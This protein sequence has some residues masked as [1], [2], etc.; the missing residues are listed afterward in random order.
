MGKPMNKIDFVVTWVDGNDPEWIIERERYVS[1]KE[2]SGNTKNRFRDWDLMRYWFRGVEKFAPWVNKIYFIT[3]GQIPRWLNIEHPKLRLIKHVDYIPAKNLPTFNSNVIELYL[4]NIPELCEQFV[5]FNDDMFLTNYSD[6]QDF[7][8][9][10]MPCD[11]V[12]LGQVQSLDYLNVFPHTILNNMAIINKY[13]NKKEVLRKN[14]K[15]YFS[16][17]YGKDLIRNILLSP[18]KYFSAFFD[19]HLPTSHLKSTFEEVWEVE[20]ELLSECGTH[21]FRSSKD[22][23]HWLMKNWRFCKGQFMPRSNTWGKCFELGQDENVFAAIKTQKYKMVCLNDSNPD[24]DF[25]VY[26]KK[27]SA[28]FES[29]LPEKSEY[30]K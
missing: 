17:L 26:Q 23:T 11:T 28:V 2:N 25:D 30:E 6:E 10:G 14:W 13:F 21:R 27:L 7:F 15:K 9:M 4:H 3:C 16:I 8:K 1:S 18:F 24:L 20:K 29:I 5:L 12:R 22:L 19:M